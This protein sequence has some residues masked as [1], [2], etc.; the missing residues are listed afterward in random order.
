MEPEMRPLKES[1]IPA[2]IEISKTTWGGHDHLPNIISEWLENPQ[3]HPYVLDDDGDVIGVA[4][5]R[6]I[7]EGRTAWLE[8]LRVHEKAR[9]KGLAHRLTNHLCDIAIQLRVK[10]MRLVT[11]GDNIAPIKL[12]A[13]IGMKQMN[14][15]QVFWK[16]YRRKITWRDESIKVEQIEPKDVMGFLEKNPDLLPLRALVHHWD[17][18]DATPE[19]INEIGKVAQYWGGSNDTGA[20]LSIS[21]EESSRVGPEWIFSLFA[22]SSQAFT[23]GLSKNLE[24]SQ[25]LGIRNLMCIHSP[26][27]EPMYQNIK[28][29]K[30]RNHEISLVLHERNLQ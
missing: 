28:W 1:D 10:R 4:N 26:D 14:V 18:Y 24:V 16:G 21:G 11:S 12:A 19:I 6:V 25:E 30:R 5:V 20:V 13:S 22:T 29:L 7:D 27:F 3:C 2:I 15:Y 8:G 17:V 23:S 9:Q